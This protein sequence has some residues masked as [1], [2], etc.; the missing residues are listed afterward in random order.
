MRKLLILLIF[1]SCTQEEEMSLFNVITSSGNSVIKTEF[2]MALEGQSNAF[3]QYGLGLS[4]Y[5]TEKINNTSA[6][7][8]DTKTVTPTL[9]AFNNES[10]S[11][12]Q[13][14]T[15]PSIWGAGIEYNL[16]EYFE[17]IG[18]TF[19]VLKL[20]QGSQKFGTD[21]SPGTFHISTFT[22][23]SLDQLTFD[24]L[25]F[26]V[27][28]QAIIDNMQFVATQGKPL[29]FTI[30]IHAE[31]DTRDS[32]AERNAYETNLRRYVEVKSFLQPNHPIYL[33]LFPSNNDAWLSAGAAGAGGRAAANLAMTNVAGLYS[34]VT[35][36]TLT[37]PMT[38]GDGA[39]GI[40]A[41]MPVGIKETSD[42]FLGQIISD[43]NL[44][45]VI[46]NKSAGTLDSVN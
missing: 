21:A 28:M 16:A 29:D 13:Y 36:V 10:F 24:A 4:G 15:P 7:W 27:N 17:S 25:T 42:A 39:T 12:W 22:L 33:R 38:L 18:K 14:N 35:A 19:N 34:N 2:N 40:H 41:S 32:T 1:I 31:S 6:F 3:G 20:A 23:G 8:W 26:G 37:D 45:A 46:E 5:A 43:Y 9:K 44:P 30:W 11:L